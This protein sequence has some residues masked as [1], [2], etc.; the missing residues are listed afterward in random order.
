MNLL[1]SGL[2]ISS[3]IAINE[4]KENPVKERI[5]IQSSEAIPIP[6]R[7]ILKIKKDIN[8]GPL[9]LYLE[10]SHAEKGNPI[11]AVIGITINKFPNCASFSRNKSLIVG[12]LDAQLEK[13]TPVRKKQTPIA[14]RCLTNSFMLQIS[15]R[16]LD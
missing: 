9:V 10:T 16:F 4:P 8:K 13:Q 3:C 5:N 15:N 12:I 14:I 11:T 1:I 6:K 7:E 2:L